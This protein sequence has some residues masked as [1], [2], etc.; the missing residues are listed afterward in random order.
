MKPPDE[1]KWEF[2]RSWLEK[3]E[4]D[5]NAGVHLLDGGAD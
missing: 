1:I 3:A 4:E 5:F 2:V